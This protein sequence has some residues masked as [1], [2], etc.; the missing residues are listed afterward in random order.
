VVGLSEGAR[1]SRTNAKEPREADK[2]SEKIDITDRTGY[3]GQAEL[4][5]CMESGRSGADL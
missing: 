5:G 3:H 2:G 4:D 1:V